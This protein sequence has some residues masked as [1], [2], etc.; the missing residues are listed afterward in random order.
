M[1]PTLARIAL[2]VL[3]A[4]ASSVPC[5]R[6]FSGSKQ[7]ATDRRAQLGHI[8]FEELV[9]MKSAWGPDLYDMPAWNAAQIDEVDSFDYEELLGE[10][11]DCAAWDDMDIAGWGDDIMMDI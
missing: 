3:P 6:M 10:D 8:V 11:V 2:D 9:I 7:I 1:F 4:Q 5:E